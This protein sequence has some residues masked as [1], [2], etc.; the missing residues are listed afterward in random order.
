VV[1][2]RQADA[3]GERAGERQREAAEQA[4]NRLPA[5]I[6]C[7]SSSSMYSRELYRYIAPSTTAMSGTTSSTT[8]IRLRITRSPSPPKRKNASVMSR[9]KRP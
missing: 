5:R 6:G 3:G 8:F 2:E 1:E 4:A 7:D 9:K